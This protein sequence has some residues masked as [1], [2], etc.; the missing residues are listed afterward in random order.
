VAQVVDATLSRFC[1]HVPTS[2]L[3]FSK[4]R[5]GWPSSPTWRYDSEWGTHLGGR[6]PHAHLFPLGSDPGRNHHQGCLCNLALCRSRLF[7]SLPPRGG[8]FLH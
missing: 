4:S 2:F 6:N 7:Y 1:L 8:C 5:D 3:R